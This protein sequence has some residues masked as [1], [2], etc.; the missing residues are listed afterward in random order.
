MSVGPK[1]FI[2]AEDPE[3]NAVGEKNNENPPTSAIWETNV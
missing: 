2:M 3:A 1:T